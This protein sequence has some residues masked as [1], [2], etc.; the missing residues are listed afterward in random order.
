VA[1]ELTKGALTRAVCEA[2]GFS[3][4]TLL[5]RRTGPAAATMAKRA[6]R[7]IAHRLSEEERREV[8]EVLHSE[9]FI[10]TLRCLRFTRSCSTKAAFSAR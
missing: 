5:R 8:L 2:L 4:S 1:L 7:R 6:P 9:R 10:S 3:R